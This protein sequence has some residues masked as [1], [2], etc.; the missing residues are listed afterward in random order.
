MDGV[1]WLTLLA[2]LLG[3]FVGAFVAG[4]AGLALGLVAAAIWVHVLPPAETATLIVAYALLVQGFAVWKLRR[5]VVV[6]R[7]VPFVIGS[8]VGIPGGVLVLRWLSPAHLRMGVGALL[9]AFSLYSLARPRLP[10]M[11]SAGPGA[12]GAVG[13][14]NGA[15]AGA[16]GLG[17]IL[18]T[19]WSGMRG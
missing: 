16:T 1:D 4:L 18:P 5:S 6:A 13:V 7:V 12:D 15:L 19:I 9:V 3:A 10:L 8:A 14:L 2:L 17:G 11:A